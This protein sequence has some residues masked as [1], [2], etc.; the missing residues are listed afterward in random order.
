LRTV[1]NGY[2]DIGEVDRDRFARDMAMAPAKTRYV[3]Y[4][5]AR[6]G[7]SWVCDLATRT[8]RLGVLG[9]SFNPNFLP[10]MTRAMNATDLDEYCDIA[11]RRR[12]R[13]DVFGFQITHHQLMA[14]FGSE[15]AFLDRF[16]TLH[17]FWLIRRDIVLQAI[18]LHKMQVTRLSHAP[19][20]SPEEIEARDRG[21]TYDRAEIKRWLSHILA[22]EQATEAMIERAGLEPLRMS[23]ERNTELKPNHLL[24]VMGR[25]MG[26]PTMRMKPVGSV[27]S[28]IATTANDDFAA[29]FREDEQAFMAEVDALR[30]PMLE[31]LVYY[32]PRRKGQPVSDD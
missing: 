5:T 16:R 18:S 11:M 22:A 10:A 2:P 9:E 13:G 26:L 3:M 24:N 15:D 28:K 7:S 8:R 30:A 12:A 17:C 14:V 32:G 25:H 31:K 20:A 23:Y 19:N 21:F 27:H 1:W 29:R 4:F 6:S